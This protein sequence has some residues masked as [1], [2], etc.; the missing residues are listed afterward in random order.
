[1]DARLDVRGG[2]IG[3][4]QAGK[5]LGHGLGQRRRGAVG[6]RVRLKRKQLRMQ[7]CGRFPRFGQMRA[8]DRLARLHAQRGQHLGIADRLFEQLAQTVAQAAL[9]AI[10]GAEHHVARHR[11]A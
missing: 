6:G 9:D 1:M 8:L 2:R 7:Q 4:G 11:F 5:R 10:V 3:L